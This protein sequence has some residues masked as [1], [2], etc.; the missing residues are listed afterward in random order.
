MGLET[1]RHDGPS[2]IGIDTIYSSQGKIPLAF[3][4][5]AGVPDK[6]IEYMGTLTGKALEFYSCFISKYPREVRVAAE[7][8]KGP[9]G[10]IL[11]RE[12]RAELPVRVRHLVDYTSR[13]QDQ[14]VVRLAPPR[15]RRCPGP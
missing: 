1:M 3:L 2:T 4:R 10:K 15:P 6:F 7:L 8:P 5:G 13:G 12:L 14:D 9:T 11:K